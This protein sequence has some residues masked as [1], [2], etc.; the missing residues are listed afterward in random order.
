MSRI[1][2]VPWQA[3]V[4]AAGGDTDLFELTPAAQKPIKLRGLILSQFSEVGDAAEE[5]VRISIIRLPATVT[6][7]NGTAVTP[8]PL[9]SADVA[10]GFTGEY[11]S[12]TVATTSGTAA[13][14]QEFAWNLRSTPC[15]LWW[16]DP[17]FAPKVKNAEALIVRMQ[18]TLA[19]DA[20]FACTAYVEEE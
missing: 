18:S 12:T 10:A 6:S 14:V 17:A 2:T 8:V 13:V 20:S 5:S 1:Y 11:N 16:P 19:D 15:E 7:G 9:D 4:T 3:T